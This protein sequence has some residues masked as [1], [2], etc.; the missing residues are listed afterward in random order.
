LAHNH[1]SGEAEPSQ[2][3]QK[4]TMRII[5]ALETIDVKVVDHLVVGGA[6]IVS[7]AERGM[8]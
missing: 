8:I 1:P 2:A 3:D 5:Q 6:E 4:I 7:F